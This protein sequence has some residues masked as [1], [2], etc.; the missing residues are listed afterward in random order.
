LLST[1]SAVARDS[2]APYLAVPKPIVDAEGR[3]EVIVDFF[4]EA[5]ETYP[6]VIEMSIKQKDQFKRDLAFHKPK[7]TNLV[8]DY[9]KKYQLT[10]SGM[11]SYVGLSFAAFLDVKQIEKLR[12]D[13]NVRLITQNSVVDTFSS[14]P[15]WSDNPAIPNGGEIHSWGRVAVNGKERIPGSTRKV[16]VIDSGV[17]YHSDLQ[18]VT[19]TSV[20]CGPSGGCENVSSFNQVVGCYAHATHVAGIIGATNGNGQTSAGVYAGV[21]IVSVTP[22]KS[23]FWD[24]TCAQNGTATAA[25][26]GY[27]LDYIYERIWKHN[28][29]KFAIVNISFNGP[30]VAVGTLLDSSSGMRVPQA[31]ALKLRKLATPALTKDSAHRKYPGALVVQ[32]AGN[33]SSNVCTVSTDWGYAYIPGTSPNAALADDGIMVVGAVK[34]DG[35]AATTFQPTNPANI[36]VST[37]PGSNY[38]ACVDIWAPGD[39]I[40][41]TW[42]AHSG[43]T[44]ATQTYAGNA[45]NFGQGWAFV[46]GTS[47]AAPHVAGVAAYLADVNN[48]ASP[49]ELEQLIRNYAQQYGGATDAANQPVKV[50]R[51]P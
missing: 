35:T 33:Q 30:R 25:E 38:G 40:V 27:A 34:V 9:E 5:E 10:H 43:D 2:L 45:P 20:V 41:S 12:K 16:F 4:D 51:I 19:R 21:D 22:Y 31:N 6:D 44:F 24:G 39:R 48:P 7:A 11:T 36:G 32:S 29:G 18:N 46:S 47:M 8:D 15:P 13:K 37:P 23:N 50:V 28:G 3:I 42:G 26:F 14:L 49:G 1:T 17:A